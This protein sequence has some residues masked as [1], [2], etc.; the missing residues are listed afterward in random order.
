LRRRKDGALSGLPVVRIVFSPDS[1]EKRS[2]FERLKRYCESKWIDLSE[3]AK[4]IL[5]EHARSLNV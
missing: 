3:Y 1:E 4:N 2:H 5:I